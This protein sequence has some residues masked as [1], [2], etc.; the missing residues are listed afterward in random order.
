MEPLKNFYS[1]DYV[2]LVAQ[3]FLTTYPKFDSENYLKDV[4]ID[5][6]NLELKE[7]MSRLAISLKPYLPESLEETYPILVS[8]LKKL[9]GA[10]KHSGMLNMFLPEYIQHFGDS[11]TE[12]ETILISLEELTIECSSEFAIRPFIIAQPD[13]CFERIEKWAVSS[14][15]HIRRL[16]SEGCRPRLP[17]GIGLKFLKEDPSAILPVLELLKDD[18]DLYVKKSVANN[19]NDISKDNAD[20]VLD[21]VERWHG[22]NEDRD[23]IIRHGLRTLLKAGH[24]RA[25]KLM[26]YGDNHKTE[27]KQFS[28]SDTE[29]PLGGNLTYKVEFEIPQTTLLRVEYKMHFA[30]ANNK[31]TTKVFMIAQK[32]FLAGSHAF[33]KG[34]SFKQLSTRKYYRGNHKIDLIING[35]EIDTQHFKV[36]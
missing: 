16:A 24:P 5:W 29:V 23:W 34:I 22:H 9:D 13:I 14:N 17:W 21:V 25:L 26:G 2:N 30:K 33:E 15:R 28:L 11:N 18:K 32:E 31:Q 3:S 1:T 10:A 4:L 12:L 7:R 20:V 35:V 8:V 27:L 19:L 6:E 36:V